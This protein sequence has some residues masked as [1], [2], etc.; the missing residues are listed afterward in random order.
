MKLH[1]DG[2]SRFIIHSR[3]LQDYRSGCFHI[4]MFLPQGDKGRAFPIA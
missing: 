4:K 1:K 2:N 3:F